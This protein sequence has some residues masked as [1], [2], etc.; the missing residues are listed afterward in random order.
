MKSP[1]KLSAAISRSLRLSALSLLTAGTALSSGSVF[2][3]NLYDIFDLA[4]EKDPQ[5]RQ[6]RANFNAQHTLL[7]QGR[8]QLLP[9]V[10]LT[11]RTSRDTTGVDG[12][13]PSGGFFAA[14]QHSFANGF[15]N[16][17]YGL[18]IRQNLLNFQA[19]YAFQSAKR[20]IRSRH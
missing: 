7:A 15:N 17:G 11:G 16:K 20:V 4:R 2:A 12:E 10:T 1:G 9:T 13:A 14:P 6:A 8:S 18:S 19:W 5:I 3:E